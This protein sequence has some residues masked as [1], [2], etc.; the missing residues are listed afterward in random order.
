MGVL[1]IATNHLALS[2]RQKLQYRA[3]LILTSFSYDASAD[4]L[5]ARLDWKKKVFNEN[6]I[7]YDHVRW[8]INH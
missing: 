1:G 2:F 6:W 3:A 4:D 8:S 7:Q 5:I